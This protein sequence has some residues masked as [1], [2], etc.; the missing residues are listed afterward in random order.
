MMRKSPRSFVPY[1]RSMKARFNGNIF[2][3]SAG[4][5]MRTSEGVEAVQEYED[6]LKAA[7]PV[8]QM[9]WSD[10]LM[11]ACRDHVKDTGPSG[12]TG[13]TGLDG[14][15]MSD[16]I[17]RYMKW[18][19]TAGENIMYTSNSP[20]QVLTDL[21]IDDGVSSRGHRTNIF[22]KAF[23]YV[24]IYTGPHKTYGRQTVFDFSGSWKEFNYN[25][26]AL[27]TPSSY[28]SYKN[29]ASPLA[30]PGTSAGGST[31]EKAAVKKSDGADAKKKTAPAKKPAA[32]KGGVNQ[33]HWACNYAQIFRLQA[34]ARKADVLT[35]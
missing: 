33:N 18:E 14:S 28:M 15:T 26:P 27:P 12:A 24:G 10:N 20:L 13:H 6:F 30:K 23:A 25:S 4:A 32:S 35:E 22:K 1:V 34:K 21:A 16:R 5:R 8:P 17:G 3:T 31:A 9:K 29:F 7:E 11:K 19:R 2:R